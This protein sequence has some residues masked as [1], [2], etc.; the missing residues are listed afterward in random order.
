MSKE[1]FVEE[2]YD[3]SKCYDKDAVGVQVM[4]KEKNKFVFANG[5]SMN[6]VF[7][8]DGTELFDLESVKRKIEELEDE[9]RV[10]KGHANIAYALNS[11]YEID[12]KKQKYKR[13]L[14]MA[15]MC[16]WEQRFWGDGIPAYER[17]FQWENRAAKWRKRWLALAE[18]PTWAKFLQLIHKEVK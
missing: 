16:A 7:A 11:L 17:Q 10:T 2:G 13:C 15:K 9:I 6:P 1:L 8:T 3:V 14:A 5:D 12:I 18:E 4:K